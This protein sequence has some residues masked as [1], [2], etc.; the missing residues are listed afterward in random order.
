MTENTYTHRSLLDK[1][2]V[3]AGARVAV[4]GVEDESFLSSLATRASDVSFGDLEPDSDAIFLNANGP[5]D[6]RRLSELRRY[7]KPNGAVWVVYRKAQKEFNENAVLRL[8]LE[9]GLVDVKVVRFS[10]THTATKFVIRRS[11]R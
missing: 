2:G 3:K 8:G 6:V 1:L 9:S 11:D 10:E 7:M 4:L 5:D